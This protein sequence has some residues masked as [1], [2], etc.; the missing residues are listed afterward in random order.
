MKLCECARRRIRAAINDAEEFRCFI[1]SDYDSLFEYLELPCSCKKQEEERQEY[2]SPTCIPMCAQCWSLADK[3]N[4]KSQSPC[5]H[6]PNDKIFID[7]NRGPVTLYLCKC[8]LVTCLDPNR[9]GPS[10]NP[11]DK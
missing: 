5:E 4:K 2:C 10:K 11:N 6:K 3:I 9:S 1:N 8:G 7:T